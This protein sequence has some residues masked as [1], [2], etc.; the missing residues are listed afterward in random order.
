M[1]SSTHTSNAMLSLS[2]FIQNT[3]LAL[4]TT[5]WQSW[6]SASRLTSQEHRTSAPRA[7]PISSRTSLASDAGPPDGE[8]TTG[9]LESIRTSWRKSTCQSSI[10]THARTSSG[11]RVSDT[12][13]TWTRASFALEVKKARTRAKATVAARWFASETESGKWPESSHGE[14]GVEKSTFPEYTFESLT[15][16]T[17][18]LKSPSSDFKIQTAFN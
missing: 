4:S 16:S 7:F 14:S 9:T 10:R 11:R 3:M 18:S 1:L 15:T 12:T 13:T 6:L 17:G 5:I 2:T 8:K